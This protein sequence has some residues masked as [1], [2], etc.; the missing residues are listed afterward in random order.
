MLCG[1]LASSCAVPALFKSLRRTTAYLCCLLPFILTSVQGRG[2]LDPVLACGTFEELAEVLFL[3]MIIYLVVSLILSDQY[4]SYFSAQG[5]NYFWSSSSLDSSH[6]DQSPV[7]NG[8]S[9][10]SLPTSRCAFGVGQLPAH[11][12]I[13]VT[14]YRLL[15]SLSGAERNVI[16]IVT[17]TVIVT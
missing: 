4:P 11:A 16:V 9:F 2:V 12:C 6:E 5:L 7:C 1:L 17:G 3:D 13:I 8:Y 14:Q 10:G 15:V